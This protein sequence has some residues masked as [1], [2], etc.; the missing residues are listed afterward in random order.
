MQGPPFTAFKNHVKLEKLHGV[1]FIGL[2]ENET[3]CKNFIF[4]ISEYLLE[5][6][7]KKKLHL[8]HFI[9]ILCDGSTD[10]SMARQEVLYVIYTDP[11]TFKPTIKFAEVTASSYNQDAPC[12]KQAIFAIF[13]KNM[14]EL[15]LKKI[16]FLASD[17]ASVNCG[18]NSQLIRLI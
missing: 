16:V 10:N 2:Y 11:E 3:G 5:E 15:V 7:V 4:R 6:G 14:L 12:L 9:A 18:K 17:G 8:A 1:K 13:R